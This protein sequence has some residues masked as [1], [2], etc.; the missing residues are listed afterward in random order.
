MLYL[1]FI[2]LYKALKYKIWKTQE[3]ASFDFH[4]YIFNILNLRK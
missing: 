2:I 4:Y 1:L 3:I